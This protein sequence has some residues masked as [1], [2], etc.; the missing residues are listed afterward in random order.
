MFQQG[1]MCMLPCTKEARSTFQL[2]MLCT[3]TTLHQTW[4]VECTLCK[5][6]HLYCNNQTYSIG[7]VTS[8]RCIP[9]PLHRVYKIFLSHSRSLTLTHQDIL[10]IWTSQ[11]YQ[12]SIHRCILSTLIQPWRSKYLSH[13]AC[14]M[15]HQL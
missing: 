12:R 3:T 13:R 7:S 10:S 2:H 6:I 1:R 15:M 14:T 11:S 9:Y 5:A 8:N 4:P